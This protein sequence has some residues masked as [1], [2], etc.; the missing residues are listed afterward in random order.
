MT[1]R[2]RDSDTTMSC[3][4]LLGPAM[5]LYH[6]R[7]APR[8]KFHTQLEILSFRV[9]SKTLGQPGSNRSHWHKNIFLKLQVA[10]GSMAAN[11]AYHHDKSEADPGSASL[12]G[13]RVLP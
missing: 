3:F 5:P 4:L 8:S 10:I 13:S 11:F 1:T 7:A 2:T 9:S 6:C 12:G